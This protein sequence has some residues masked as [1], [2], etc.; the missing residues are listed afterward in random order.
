MF[1]KRY[2]SSSFALKIAPHIKIPLVDNK[3]SIPGYFFEHYNNIYNLVQHVKKSEYVT[4]FY[5]Q[6]NITYYYRKHRN[7]D[8]FI[9]PDILKGSYEV[10]S[11]DKLDYRIEGTK[12]IQPKT[13]LIKTDDGIFYLISDNFTDSEGKKFLMILNLSNKKILYKMSQKDNIYISWFYPM[14]NVIVPILR[15]SSEG[16]FLDL[17]NLSNSSTNTIKC[18][19]HCLSQLIKRLIEESKNINS[20]LSDIVKNIASFYFY[21]VNYEYQMHENKVPH[22]KRI[23]IEFTFDVYG[24]TYYYNMHNVLLIV[25][26]VDNAISLYL[27]FEKSNIGI[28]KSGIPVKYIN[29]LD[30]KFLLKK[31]RFAGKIVGI[32]LHNQLYADNCYRIYEDEDGFRISGWNKHLG[33]SYVKA[34]VYSCKKY[35]I[36]IFALSDESIR[37]NVSSWEEWTAEGIAITDTEY[38]KTMVW[39]HESH[40]DGHCL[41]YLPINYHYY[42]SKYQKLIFLSGNYTCLSIMDVKKINMLFKQFY[43]KQNLE[44]QEKSNTTLNDFVESFYIMSMIIEEVARKHKMRP[45]FISYSNIRIMGAYIDKKLDILYIAVKYNMADFKNDYSVNNV[46]LFMW[47]IRED[48]VKLELLWYKRVDSKLLYYNSLKS[49]YMTELKRSMPNMIKL[50]LNSPDTVLMNLH[51]AYDAYRHIFIDMQN[52][53]RSARMGEI[54]DNLESDSELISK[55]DN[56]LLINY[57]KLNKYSVL[58]IL[59][60]LCFIV[61]DA[62]MMVKEF[63]H[64]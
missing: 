53:R 49:L 56:F 39:T 16:L 32:K 57:R 61:S 28:Y 64:S 36:F 43:Q 13:L 23:L 22:T 31:H 40:V 26:L 9:I 58:D 42:S 33:G 5:T 47:P 17:V 30:S 19:L 2:D 4:Y 1:F 35:K 63:P 46:G 54:Y 37:H 18:D 15:V 52:N 27:S 8:C 3:L 11:I 12:N 7:E 44:C 21:S 60:K 51:L 14:A 34:S 55:I 45:A 24:H 6:K 50:E 48:N 38:H 62:A 25:Q 20:D 29:G 41:Q 59:G 10:V